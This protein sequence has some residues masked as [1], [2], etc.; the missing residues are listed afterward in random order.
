[1][2]VKLTNVGRI[3]DLNMGRGVCFRMV[4]AGSICKVASYFAQHFS[5]LDGAASLADVFSY[6]GCSECAGSCSE[7]LPSQVGKS[8]TELVF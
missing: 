3:S 8:G 4:T 7:K 2:A 1:M 5:F 6:P